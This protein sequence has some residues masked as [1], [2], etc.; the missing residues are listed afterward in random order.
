MK[1]QEPPEDLYAILITLNEKEHAT[2]K[3]N[4]N[5]ALIIEPRNAESFLEEC[6]SEAKLFN[7]SLFP[8][9]NPSARLNFHLKP[10]N[11]GLI[12][13]KKSERDEVTVEVMSRKSLISHPFPKVAQYN[14]LR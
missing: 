1:I 13:T 2:Y 6:K 7:F 9:D 5:T 4:P 10:K 8:L 11:R 3:F 12:V 14:L